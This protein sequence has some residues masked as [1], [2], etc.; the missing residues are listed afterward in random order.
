MTYLRL[1]RNESVTAVIPAYNEERHIGK[2]LEVLRWVDKFSQIIVVDDGSTD[3]TMA[4]VQR[5]RRWDPRIQVLALP[6]N[7]GKAGAMVTGVHAS[8]NDMIV[9]LDADLIGLRPENVRALIEPV[10][11]DQCAMSLGI[12]RHGRRQTDLTHKLIPFLSGQRCLRWSL[13]KETPDLND[14]RWGVEVALSFY[15]WRHDYN[16]VTIPW[17]GVTHAMRPEKVEGLEG[18]WSHVQMWLDIGKYVAQHLTD[19]DEQPVSAE[20]PSHYYFP[21]KRSVVKMTG[22]LYPVLLY[23][24]LKFDNRDPYKTAEQPQEFHERGMP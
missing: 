23:P 24:I 15:A 6:D 3:D 5:Q 11:S 16:V 17:P 13:F 10:H 2:V 18:Y 21:D 7:R 1:F 4:I 22:F 19:S 9:F 20:G 8:R 14:A 12:F